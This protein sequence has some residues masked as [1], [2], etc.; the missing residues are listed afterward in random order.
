[1]RLHLATQGHRK[2]HKVLEE[3]NV[4]N[5][6]I[7]YAYVSK[8]QDLL[9]LHET[10]WPEAL[11]IDSG[12][13]SVWTKGRTINIQDYIRFCKEVK[14]VV[15]EKVK[16][17]FVNLDVLPGKFGERPTI[18]QREESAIAGYTNLKIMQ[19][20]GITPIHVFHQ[21]EDF[22]WL[23]LI[24]K[25]LPY[26]GI[27]PAND[28]SMKE[29][30]AWLD[31]VFTITRDKIKT[32]GFAVTSHNQILTYPFYS[33]DSSSWNAGARYARTPTFKQGK[34]KTFAYKDPKQFSSFIHASTKNPNLLDD[35]FAMYEEGIKA[36]ME[37]E[38]FATKLWTERGIIYND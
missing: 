24:M 14:Q 34:I 2:L 17:H 13:F 28:V 31:K 30:M 23:K 33:V 20:E 27:S 37:L 38:E 1:M 32:H 3:F 12:A 22:K 10:W 35:Y 36:F 16:L 26:I 4:K 18:E 21:H 25:E 6:L 5:I 29:K 19:Q 9:K 11:I 15:P 7:S 8:V